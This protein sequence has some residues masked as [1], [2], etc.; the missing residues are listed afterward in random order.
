MKIEKWT[1]IYNKKLIEI[2]VTAVS[3]GYQAFVKGNPITKC[4]V[5]LEDLNNVLY[6]NGCQKIE[7]NFVKGKHIVLQDWQK[8]N[9]E[10][11]VT[12]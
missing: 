11:I 1:K 9:W 7:K 6:G 2:Q 3:W 10:K 12:L 5:L 4:E 8:I